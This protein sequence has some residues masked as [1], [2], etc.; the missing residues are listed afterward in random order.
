M[1]F[2]SKQDNSIVP[3]SNHEIDK[4]DILRNDDGLKTPRGMISIER[5]KISPRTSA[6]DT[7]INEDDLIKVH[8]SKYD[9][10]ILY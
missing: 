4:K 3:I 7:A 1:I 6:K 8:L 9:T 5:S 2:N 10:Y